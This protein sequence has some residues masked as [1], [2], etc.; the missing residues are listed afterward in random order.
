MQTYQLTY[1]RMCDV[2]DANV[3]ENQYTFWHIG[4]MVLLG[5]INFTMLD[6]SM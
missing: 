3:L 2:I 6:A 1:V 5:N 4:S